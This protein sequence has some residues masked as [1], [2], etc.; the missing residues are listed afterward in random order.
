[1]QILTC[2]INPAQQQADE[3][4]Q[5]QKRCDLTEVQGDTFDKRPSSIRHRV[6]VQFEF[7]IQRPKPTLYRAMRAADGSFR[8][9]K[10]GLN[11]KKFRPAMWCGSE[12]SLLKFKEAVE[13]YLGK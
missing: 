1:M 6:E 9:E 12:E 2:S 10:R 4:N 11:A 8:M 7:S 3:V 5:E 13:Y